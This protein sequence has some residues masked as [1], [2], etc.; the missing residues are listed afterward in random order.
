MG[1]VDEF[2][3]CM[4]RW[5]IDISNGI[6]YVDGNKVDCRDLTGP[7]N[8]IIFIVSEYE[9]FIYATVTCIIDGVN[10][11][12][13][14]RIHCVTRPYRVFVADL[15]TVFG[16][17]LFDYTCNVLMH[18]G[19]AIGSYLYGS[20]GS[21][22]PSNINILHRLIKVSSNLIN[23]LIK[24]STPPLVWYDLSRLPSEYEL[25]SQFESISPI[26][27]AIYFFDFKVCQN[28]GHSGR[29]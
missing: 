2:K 7:L 1:L 9:S 6:M 5:K 28:H 23:T 11:I 4:S 13:D 27:R 10:K 20:Y 19:I 14:F 21:T 16:G 15:V 29:Y 3:R 8:E 22:F 18:W 12:V 24:E 26:K 17:N 25:I